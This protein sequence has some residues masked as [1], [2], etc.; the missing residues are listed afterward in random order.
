MNNLEC[1]KLWKVYSKWD[2]VKSLLTAFVFYSLL[3]ALVIMPTAKIMYFYMTSLVYFMIGIYVY[4]AGL[5]IFFSYL[6]VKT[7]QTYEQPSNINFDKVKTSL[8]TIMTI[9]TFVL[10]AWI[11]LYIN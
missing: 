5:N 8:S 10:L 7:L 6:F 2:I 11:Y 1:V 4:L 3:G 9:L